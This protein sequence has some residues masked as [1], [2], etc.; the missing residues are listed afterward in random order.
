MKKYRR[1][2]AMLLCI[3]MVFTLTNGVWAADG[4]TQ[5]VD[6]EALEAAIT[7]AKATSAVAE[8]AEESDEPAAAPTHTHTYRLAADSYE[9]T[10]TTGGYRHYRCTVCMHDY[11]YTTDPMVYKTNPK[12]GEAITFDYAANPYLPNYEFMPDNELHVLWSKED[13]E[14]RA[15]ALGSHDK[16]LSGW[17]GDDITCWSAPVYD[18]TDWRFEA[19]L[20]DTGTFFACDFNYDLL[21]DQCVLYAFPFFGNPE[22]N[23][24]H[25]W[26]NGSSVPD[27]YFDIPLTEGA[28][29]VGLDGVNHFDPAIYIDEE[30]NFL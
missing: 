16:K 19:I 9:A 13:N 27:S 24:T 10:D 5:L 25:L 14:W 1:L 8:T 6:P 30:G 11:S 3:V 12:T 28:G 29:V 2:L 22:M 4:E 23:G 18:L 26:V 21:T 17:C 7:A 15:Y 20:R